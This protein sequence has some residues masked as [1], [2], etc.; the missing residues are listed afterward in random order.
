LQIS[1][2]LREGSPL[3][4]ATPGPLIDRL[5]YHDASLKK[6][7]EEDDASPLTTVEGARMGEFELTFTVLKV[8][9]ILHSCSRHQADPNDVQDE[10]FGTH[11]SAMLALALHELGRDGEGCEGA[12]GG[13]VVSRL[14]ELIAAR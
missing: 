3:P 5:L 4:E 11:A 6:F 12:G 9:L 13:S 2:A 8:R 14:Q 10:R 1:L 7:S